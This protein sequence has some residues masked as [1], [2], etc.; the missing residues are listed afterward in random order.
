[1]QCGIFAV[2]VRIL[3]SR[4]VFLLVCGE[5][6]KRIELQP[7]DPLARTLFA[8]LLRRNE[9]GNLSERRQPTVIPPSVSYPLAVMTE[10]E[11][12]DSL[13]DL[14]DKVAVVTGQVQLWNQKSSPSC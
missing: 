13:Q 9:L 5:A 14:T 6:T 4:F 2:L 11:Y 7:F 12:I 8:N 10:E 3:E 1:M